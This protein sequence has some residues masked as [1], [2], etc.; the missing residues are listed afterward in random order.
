MARP[1][2]IVVVLSFTLRVL[3][4]AAPCAWRSRTGVDAVGEAFRQGAAGSPGP[5]PTSK[6]LA[7]RNLAR[8]T[9]AVTASPETSWWPL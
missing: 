3:R 7:A 4:R 5:A 8:V 1:N 9:L 2:E 6:P